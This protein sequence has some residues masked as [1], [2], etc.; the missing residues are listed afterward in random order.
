MDS[1]PSS[2]DGKSGGHEAEFDDVVVHRNN[3]QLQSVESVSAQ[4]SIDPSS[5]YTKYLTMC[6][7][8]N[9]PPFIVITKSDLDAQHSYTRLPK[10]LDKIQSVVALRS[11]HKLSCKVIE[12]P[13][14][15][16]RAARA[17]SSSSVST[18]PVM[19]TSCVNGEGL[20]VLK[21]F[22]FS[23]QSNVGWLS[24]SFGDA[25]EFGIDEVFMV[26]SVGVVVS[27]IVRSGTVRMGDTLSVGPDKQGQFKKVTVSSIHVRRKQ[28]SYAFAGQLASFHL[29]E[30][31]RKDE[32]RRGMV[33]VHSGCAV[34]KQTCYS[35]EADI[36][37]LTA[38]ALREGSQP[39]LHVENIRQSA[40]ILHLHSRDSGNEDEGDSDDENGGNE[41]DCGVTAVFTFLHC[42]EF[43]RRGMK[44][45]IRKSH[46]PIAIGRVTKLLDSAERPLVPLNSLQKPQR[47]RTS[48]HKTDFKHY[49]RKWNLDQKRKHLQPPDKKDSVSERELFSTTD[50]D[51]DILSNRCSMENVA[52]PTLDGNER[53]STGNQLEA[54]DESHTADIPQRVDKVNMVDTDAVMECKNVDRKHDEHLIGNGRKRGRKRRG[55]GKGSGRVRKTYSLVW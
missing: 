44:I 49:L 6:E 14:E 10:M 2:A 24:A 17:L 23:L 45:I 52:V 25:V 8:I 38:C 28:A 22:L 15:A 29:S 55:K 20:E 54:L 26:Q 40:H 19:V 33:L 37:V 32:L 1:P 31:L 51:V 43:I 4:K 42:P 50:D 7:S 41:K 48:K 36:D 30:V 9:V 27:G 16:S 34:E 12:S 47:F 5:D 11:G 18:V 46:G 39:I 13:S 3:M 35:F 21:T 53:E